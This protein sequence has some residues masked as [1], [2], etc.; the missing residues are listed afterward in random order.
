M[1]TKFDSNKI[2]KIVIVIVAV[3]FLL[4]AGFVLK[5]TTTESGKPSKEELVQAFAGQGDASAE[6]L[7]NY[8]DLFECIVDN[9]YDKL[10]SERLREIVDASGQ[11]DTSA[12]EESF[13]EAELQ[14]MVRAGEKCDEIT[15][16]PPGPFDEDDVSPAEEALDDAADVALNIIDEQQ[17]EDFSGITIETLNAYDS[18]LNFEDGPLS[19]DASSRTIAVLYIKDSEIELQSRLDDECHYMRV[20]PDGGTVSTYSPVDSGEECPPTPLRDPDEL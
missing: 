3:T 11:E 10:S 16:Q 19:E 2:A 14:I 5:S 9:I 17:S 4:F 6:Y 12:F 15:N 1:S 13:S 7:E 18:D 8:R 20:D